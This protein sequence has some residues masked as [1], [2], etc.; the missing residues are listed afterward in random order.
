MSPN[1]ERHRAPARFPR[2][3]LSSHPQNLS[4]GQIRQGL[5]AMVQLLEH[6]FLSRE[7]DRRDI[8]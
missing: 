6:I 5:S 4:D 2:R 1:V 8:V 3:E 7:L